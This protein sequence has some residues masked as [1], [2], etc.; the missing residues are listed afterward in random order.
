MGVPRYQVGGLT[1]AVVSDGRMWRDGGAVFGAVPKVLWSRVAP[2]VNE[3]NE[4]PLALNC[5]LLESGGKTVLIDTGYGDKNVAMLEK[6][7]IAVE[8]GRL[9]A[10]LKA[11]GVGAED[12][13]VVINSHLHSDH[14]GWNTRRVGTGAG[15]SLQPTFPNAR[16]YIQRAEWEAALHPNE[17]SRAGYDQE[18]L[19]PL[20]ATGQVEFLDGEQQVTPDI[21]VLKAPGHTA[22]HASVVIS[23]G[24]ETAVYLGDLVHHAVQLERMAW[25]C[26][27]DDLPLMSMETKRKIVAEAVANNHL[28][29]G[30][31]N[32]FPGVAR[33]QMSEGRTKYVAEAAST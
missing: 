6:R 10:S 17:R 22:D 27:Y 25:V 12:V 30:A 32:T 5:M 33:L 13:D 19:L 2:E 8:H 29:I 11:A 18:N 31:H 21:R 24:G 23:H 7:G 16:Y 28:L 20:E 15:E 14:C 1:V 26:A 9:L 4:V 3:R